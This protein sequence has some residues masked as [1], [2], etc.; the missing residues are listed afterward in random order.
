MRFLI[1]TSSS[2]P[3]YHCRWSTWSLL[4]SVALPFFHLILH[5]HFARMCLRILSYSSGGGS[6]HSGFS[7][8]CSSWT[9]KSATPTSWSLAVNHSK[10]P[11][12]ARLGKEEA[13]NEQRRLFEFPKAGSP[14]RRFLASGRS[15]GSCRSFRCMAPWMCFLTKIH[16]MMQAAIFRLYRSAQGGFLDFYR[17]KLLGNDLCTSSEVK[18]AAERNSPWSSC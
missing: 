15:F 9:Q 5:L 7:T 4:L 18:V 16:F 12:G 2:Q 6:W 17:R 10:S 11:T 3:A 1:P 8:T 14:C 13:Q